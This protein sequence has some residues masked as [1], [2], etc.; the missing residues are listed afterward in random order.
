[1]T[2]LLL[3][4]V[5]VVLI[6][7]AYCLAALSR[8]G[9]RRAAGPTLL[10]VTTITVLAGRMQALGRPKPAWLELP[11]RADVEI[12]HVEYREGHAIRVELALPDVA[13]PMLYALPWSEDQAARLHDVEKVAKAMGTTT[14]MPAPFGPLYDGERQPY[15]KPVQPLP[16]KI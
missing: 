2:P 16:P 1:M 11:S 10:A 13:E 5:V 9:W 6:N 14:M 4:F 3:C 8:D 7:G 15:P 12:L